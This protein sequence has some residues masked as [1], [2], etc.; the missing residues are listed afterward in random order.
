MHKFWFNFNFERMCRFTLKL[1]HINLTVPNID[2]AIDYYI[3]VLGFSLKEQYQ[4]NGMNFTFLTDGNI[5]YEILENPTL[6]QTVI[7]HIAYVSDDIQADFDI[8][9]NQGLTISNINYLDFLFDNGV[10]FF[11]I[12]GSGNE[13]IEF[14][15]KR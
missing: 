5:V 13:K 8:Y 4:K 2:D 7:D 14:C 10:Y 9:N 6:K 12:K 1:D 15:Q 3:N 11:F